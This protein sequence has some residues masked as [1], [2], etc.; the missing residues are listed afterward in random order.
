MKGFIMSVPGQYDPPPQKSG[1]TY[2]LNIV[3]IVL[4]VLI[5]GCGGLCAGC[6]VIANRAGT[7]FK[8]SLEEGLQSMQ[9]AVVYTQAMESV[10]ENAAVVERLGEPIAPA[11]EGEGIKWPYKR[12]GTGEL[13]PDGET[14]QFDVKGPKGKGIVTALAKPDSEGLYRATNITVMFDDSSSIDVPPKAEPADDK[15]VPEKAE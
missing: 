7:A 13:N 6:L 2:V 15:P 11:D 1:G 4:A 9:L 12:Q 10:K 8:A 3:L 5:L 14:L